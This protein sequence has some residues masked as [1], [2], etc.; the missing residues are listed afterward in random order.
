MKRKIIAIVVCLVVFIAFTV[1]CICVYRSGNKPIVQNEKFISLDIC[2][3]YV[4]NYKSKKKKDG[5]KI[6]ISAPDF[7]KVGEGLSEEID[8]EELSDRDI[9]KYIEE[10][11]V[12]EK[13]Y[14]FI[15]DSLEEE[16]ILKS[17][18]TEVARELA[19]F[20][21]KDV[22]IKEQWEAKEYEELD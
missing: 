15:V 18:E 13:K 19:I 2:K 5:Y 8:I 10:R 22:E 12:P 16:Q 4:E 21:L 9:K 14:T 7:V 6:I 3:D 17:F 11:N 20:A 1:V